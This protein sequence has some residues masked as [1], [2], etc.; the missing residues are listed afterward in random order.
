MMILYAKRVRSL[1]QLQIYC[2]WYNQQWHYPVFYIPCQCQ[3]HP[4]Q[5]RLKIENWMALKTIAL[6]M[7]NGVTC[8]F[9][10]VTGKWKRHPYS[11]YVSKKSPVLSLLKKKQQK[12]WQKWLRKIYCRYFQDGRCWRQKPIL[13][14]KM[15]AYLNVILW[16]I[17]SRL[18]GVVL[19]LCVLWLI[20]CYI[21]RETEMTTRCNK[22]FKKNLK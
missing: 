1:Y 13:V 17:F 22:I 3:N 5:H 14:W 18:Y 2:G 21:L 7:K 4:Y 20:R 19:L 8:C 9:P 15:V 10:D 6:K 11:G 16:L 12:C